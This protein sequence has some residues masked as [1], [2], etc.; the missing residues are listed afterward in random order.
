MA[1]CC[2]SVGVRYR[3][4]TRFTEALTAGLAARPP[5]HEE[6][7]YWFRRAADQGNALAQYS[8]GRTHALGQGVPRDYVA[9]YV[10]ANLA[11]EQGHEDPGRLR[12]LVASGMSAEQLAA[13]QRAANE[14]KSTGRPRQ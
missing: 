8:L 13:A 2:S 11:T 6:A 4:P 1:A 14:W 9:A 7:A 5:N 12:E 3:V 10:W